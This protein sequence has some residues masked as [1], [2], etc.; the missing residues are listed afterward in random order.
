[1]SQTYLVHDPE[2]K[3]KSLQMLLYLQPHCPTFKST[4]REDQTSFQCQDVLF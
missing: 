4:M 2:F 3:S 1:M